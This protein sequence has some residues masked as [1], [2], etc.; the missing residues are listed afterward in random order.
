MT[1]KARESA[2]QESS[3]EHSREM[4]LQVPRLGRK[5]S[6]V[7]GILRSECYAQGGMR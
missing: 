2:G 3:K 4:E 6:S 5:R 7:V 1:F